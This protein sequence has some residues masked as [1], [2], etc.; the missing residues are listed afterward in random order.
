[1]ISVAFGEFVWQ[2]YV[3]ANYSYKERL[4]GWGGMEIN[5]NSKYIS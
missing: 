5:F 1:M 2:Q 4:G 3:N